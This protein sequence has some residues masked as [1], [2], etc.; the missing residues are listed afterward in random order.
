MSLTG[1]TSWEEEAQFRVAP[2][3]AKDTAASVEQSMARM[4]YHFAEALPVTHSRIRDKRRYTR[5]QYPSATVFW[6][7]D[8][9]LFF[10]LWDA[11]EGPFQ[12]RSPYFHQAE[13]MMLQTLS[14]TYGRE[15]VERIEFNGV[16]D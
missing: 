9:D 16:P 13:E 2:G 5:F 6:L 10:Q 3:G 11:G 1:C 14:E 4:H 12:R 7:T 15:H 8:G